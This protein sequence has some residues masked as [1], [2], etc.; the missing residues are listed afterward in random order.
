M[1]SYYNMS[2]IMY[3][4]DKNDYKINFELSAERKE[5][6]LMLL[7]EADELSELNER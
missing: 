5:S 2:S 1:V 3:L 7:T 4:P 6:Q